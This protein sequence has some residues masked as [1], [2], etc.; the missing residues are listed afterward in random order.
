MKNLFQIP[1]TLDDEDYRYR[2]VLNVFLWILFFANIIW[3]S[4]LLIPEE[5]VR[6][7]T[8][9]YLTQALSLGVFLAIL[10]FVNA[11]N[12][13]PSKVTGVLF[14]A[15]FVYLVS[16]ADAPQYMI[17]NRSSLLWAI[18]IIISAAILPWWGV[19]VAAG[20][21]MLAFIVVTLSIPR[22]VNPFS[23]IMLA[24]IA[25]VAW[26]VASIQNRSIRDTHIEASNR[27]AVLQSISD[28]VVVYDNLGKILSVNPA[29]E[30]MLS[31]EA[32]QEMIFRTGEVYETGGKF[33]SVIR[34]AVPGLGTVAVVRDETR[35]REIE[36]A[37]DSMMATVSHELRTPLASIMG[38]AEMMR[39]MIRMN[40]APIETLDEMAERMMVNA[41]R[42]KALVSDLLDRAQ[43]EA[44]S[45]RIRTEPYSLGKLLENVEFLMKSQ[46]VDKGIALVVEAVDLP[47]KVVGDQ[48]R[49]HQVV[50]NLVGNAIKFT[51]EGQVTLRVSRDDKLLLIDVEDTGVGIPAA[52]LPD[53][54]EPFRRGSNYATR[55][56]QGAGLGLSISKQLI[57]LM[58]GTISVRSQVGEG[59]TFRVT[60]PLITSEVS[61]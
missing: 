38:Y 25:L 22:E 4:L 1:R 14:L 53:I 2:Q 17:D 30:Q 8:S 31:I 51:E 39:Q 35:R 57:D 32:L 55:R 6:E 23:L 40:K 33:F 27:K 54:F 12:V 48:E 15:V 3:G 59:T 41:G 5:N 24:V 20:F 28:G 16:Y 9:A 46:A 34:S 7:D 56:H 44:G 36:R 11:R 45:I 61:Q 47:E 37:K 13:I 43:I 60:L 10:L 42:L 52:Q 19:F 58:G 29:I 26:V 21:S 49:V 18:P 50:V